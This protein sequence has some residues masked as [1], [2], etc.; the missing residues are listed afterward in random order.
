M[1]EALIGQTM[2]LEAELQASARSIPAMSVGDSL[3]SI[4]MSRS[5]D[6]VVR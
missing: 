5:F 6:A 1:S 2:E 3:P 4:R